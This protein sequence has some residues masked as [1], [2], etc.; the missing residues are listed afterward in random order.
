M[1][2]ATLSSVGDDNYSQYYRPKQGDFDPLLNCQDE[3]P[4]DALKLPRSQ[5]PLFRDGR[6]PPRGVYYSAAKYFQSSMCHYRASDAALAQL[7]EPNI[8]NRSMR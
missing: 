6:K 1:S 5:F 2:G 7:V 3:L 8:E 4:R